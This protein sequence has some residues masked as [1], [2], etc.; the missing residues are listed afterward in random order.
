MSSKTR[1]FKI[2]SEKAF[3]SR[4]SKNVYLSILCQKIAYFSKFCQ[5]KVILQASVKKFFSCKV[6]SEKGLCLTIP[7]KFVVFQYFVK[8]W[9]S[10]NNLSKNYHPSTFCKKNRHLSTFCQKK[11]ILQAFVKKYLSCKITNRSRLGLTD[12]FSYLYASQ[13]TLTGIFWR[14]N[15]IQLMSTV[16]TLKLSLL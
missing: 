15:Q 14:N 2:L 13:R 12:L 1:S 3:L 7:S 4:L 6:L 9:L 8:K 5:K 16:Q 11:V 10:C